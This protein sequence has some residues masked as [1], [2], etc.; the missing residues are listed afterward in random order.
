M[1][2]RWA[3]K[4]SLTVLSARSEEEMAKHPG[5]STLLVGEITQREFVP[6]PQAFN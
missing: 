5:P 2:F 3:E 6:F 4:L 1:K